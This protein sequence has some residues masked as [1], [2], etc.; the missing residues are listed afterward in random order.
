[1]R[2]LERQL[3]EARQELEAWLREGYTATETPLDHYG[4]E[5]LREAINALHR[6]PTTP[7]A[8]R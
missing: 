5:V 8:T 4:R 7:E 1:M 2:G 6:P 3:A